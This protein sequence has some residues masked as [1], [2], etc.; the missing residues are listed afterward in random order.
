M[1]CF[2]DGD[3]ALNESSDGMEAACMEVWVRCKGACATWVAGGGDRH[4]RVGDV[5]SDNAV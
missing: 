5:H 1:F 3:Y 2:G 4:A